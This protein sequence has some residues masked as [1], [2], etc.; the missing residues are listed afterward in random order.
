MAEHH[1]VCPVADSDWERFY[2]RAGKVY[3]LRTS[4]LGPGLDTYM[5]L[6]DSDAKKILAEN[7]DG[8]DGVASRIDFYPLR[9]DWYFIQVKNA[10]DISAL[11]WLNANSA[12]NSRYKK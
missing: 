10:G 7:D 1:S 8:G 2:A 5:L 12:G 11:A 9:D 3:T 4:N 6:F